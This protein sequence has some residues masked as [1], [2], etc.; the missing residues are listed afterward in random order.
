MSP[1][2]ENLM[3]QAFSSGGCETAYLHEIKTS[4]KERTTWAVFVQW[5]V[6][7]MKGGDA[8]DCVPMTVGRSESLWPSG[9]DSGAGSRTQ[10]P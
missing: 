1:A 6:N 9:P 7:N 10:K 4:Q 2:V 8:Y 5:G 3:V